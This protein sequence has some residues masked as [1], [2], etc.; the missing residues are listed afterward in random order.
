MKNRF[1]YFFGLTITTLLIVGWSVQQIGL[2]A[3]SKSAE[4]ASPE[5]PQWR[6][7]NRDGLSTET[8]LLKSWPEGGPK[9]LWRAASG[10]GYSAISIAKGRAY[11]MYGQG[12]D[13]VL[14]CLDAATGKELWRYRLD[15]KFYNDQ[16]NGP[17][18]TPVVDGDLVFV[19]GAQSMLAAVKAATGEKVWQHDLKRDY[20]GRIPTWG[21]SSTPLV[22]GE[23]LLVDVGGKEGSA[24]CA[25]N[26]KDGRLV[27]KSHSDL[28]GYSAPI[29][30]TVNGVRQV[31][32]F[33]GTA[34]VG[35]SP[36]DGKIFWRHPWQTSYD[37][38]AATPIFIPNDKVFISSGYG[39]GATVLQIKNQN[40]TVKVEPVWKS[41][42][43][44][45]H[46][47]SSVL[48]GNYL[49][50]FDDGIFVCVDALTGEQ[51]WQQRGY[52]KGSLIYADGHLIVLGE[53][54]K[55]GLVEATPTAYKEKA[56]AQPLTGKC[57]TMPA[58]AG[59]KLYLRNQKEMLCLDMTGKN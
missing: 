47:S 54:G 12:N 10:E 37:V 27:W 51:Q 35:V 24:L 2:P 45:N 7:P 46:F 15:S 26:K 36:K 28:P 18:S 52:Q 11:T 50:G 29:A 8:G 32:F 16:G 19:Q 20:G 31:I 42:V 5:W 17:R 1:L 38:N 14:V 6:G 23:L 30:I 3:K 34:A 4:E 48:V 56:S 40:G 57:W 49:Y 44:K 41:R 13:E 58:L 43:I 22:E 39:V 9:V 25:F 55:L 59:G 21:V 33:T 53:Q